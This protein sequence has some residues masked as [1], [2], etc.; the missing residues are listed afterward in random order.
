MDANG[1]VREQNEGNNTN[2]ECNVAQ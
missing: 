2:V 1:A